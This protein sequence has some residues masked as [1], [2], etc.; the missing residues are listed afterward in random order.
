MPCLCSGFGPYEEGIFLGQNQGWSTLKPSR[1]T[2]A[3]GEV[4]QHKH[5][6]A[7]FFNH[8]KH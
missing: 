2:P 4:P 3:L 8:E 5:R 7:F 6:K 1:T